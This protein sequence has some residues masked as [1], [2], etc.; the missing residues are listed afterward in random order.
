MKDHLHFDTKTNELILVK[1]HIFSNKFITRI[2]IPEGVDDWT[3]IV[4]SLMVAYNLEELELH[5]DES[6]CSQHKDD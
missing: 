6:D 1:N 2:K 4:D 5:L 3:E